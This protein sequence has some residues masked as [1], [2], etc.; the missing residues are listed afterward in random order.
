MKYP[1]E[2]EVAKLG[3]VSRVLAGFILFCGIIAAAG[4]VFAIATEPFHPAAI[5]GGVV[6]LVILHVSGCIVFKGFAPKYILFTHG[7]K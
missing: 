4:L 5:I 2:N 7:P 1:T 3:I 6:V